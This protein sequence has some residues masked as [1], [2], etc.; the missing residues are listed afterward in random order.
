MPRGCLQKAK[1][2]E[3]NRVGNG[4]RDAPSGFPNTDIVQSRTP[5]MGYFYLQTRLILT[6]HDG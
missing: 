4:L 5:R 2:N 6:L 3:F 1:A